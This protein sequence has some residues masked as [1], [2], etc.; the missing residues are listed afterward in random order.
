MPAVRPS[1]RIDA[2]RGARVRLVLPMVALTLAVALSGAAAAQ[3]DTITPVAGA[4]LSR[5]SCANPAV[6]QCLVVNQLRNQPFSAAG[7]GLLRINGGSDTPVGLPAGYATL[8]VACPSATSC[9]AVGYESTYDPQHFTHSPEQLAVV[10]ITNGP[11][12]APQTL[13]VKGQLEGVACSTAGNCV[14]VGMSRAVP[15]GPTTGSVVAIRNG[16]AEP[17]QNL[18]GLSE[19]YAVACFDSTH[20]VA[21]GRATSSDGVLVPVTNGVAGSPEKLSGVFNND[22]MSDVTCVAGTTD[23]VAT[24]YA[25]RVF[26][27]RNGAPGKA[28][29]VA[30]DAGSKGLSLSGLSCPNTGGC[31]AVGEQY[32]NNDE[33]T[34]KIWPVALDGTPGAATTEPGTSVLLKLQCA[35]LYSCTATGLT[36]SQTAAIVQ[37]RRSP[38]SPATAVS[39]ALAVKGPGSTIAAILK[40]GGYSTAATAPSAGVT[41]ITWYY[42]PRGAHLARAT[43]PVVVARGSKRFSRPGTATI[44]IALTKQGRAL[45]KKAHAI[46]LTTLGS[47]APKHGKTTTKRK[48]L[49]LARH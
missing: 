49:T 27:I 24:S 40:T 48:A 47:F 26:P 33:G 28:Q 5:L 23:C 6:P 25:G 1:R 10:P 16:V 32:D 15:G 36:D 35:T 38:P 21:V 8:G 2:A 34:G 19:L 20:C 18:A 11:A 4:S 41:K 45:L 9:M 31:L 7:P 43:P 29:M 39:N 30:R 42:L 3:A 14:A 22:T 17:A 12:G 37:I 13:A 44:K 46:K